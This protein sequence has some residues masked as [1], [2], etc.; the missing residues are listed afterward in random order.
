MRINEDSEKVKTDVKDR[1]IIGLLAENS[2]LPLTRMCKAAMLSR[3]AID[4]RISRLAQ[5]GVLLKCT[6]SINRRAFGFNTFHAFM[7]VDES[8]KEK[9][10][11]LITEL[12]NH[13][14]TISLMEYS[15]RW[16]IEWTLT[17]RNA[18]EYDEVTSAVVHKYHDTLLERDSMEVIKHYTTIHLPYGFY[19][20]KRK[21][22]PEYKKYYMDNK[23]TDILRM[24]SED[25]RTST[26]TM[27]KTAKMS[28]DAVSLRMKK[29]EENGVIKGYTSMFNLSTLGYHLYTFA[30]QV[31]ELTPDE[32]KKFDRFVNSHPQVIRAVKTMGMWDLMLYITAETPKAFHTTVKEL[33]DHFSSVMRTYQTWVSYKEHC[34]NPFP[35]VIYETYAKGKELN[36]SEV[37]N[38]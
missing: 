27:G 13:P 5:K 17:A 38:D 28:P 12:K 29:M 19:N 23:D 22:F 6:P 24:L 15:D 9:I 21:V 18:I 10:G 3:D 26:Y 1:K 30:I 16:D 32:E 33:K 2:R 11:K 36:K 34:Y 7:V 25:C 8:S 35:Q 37:L 14:N 20:G 4:Y 31:K